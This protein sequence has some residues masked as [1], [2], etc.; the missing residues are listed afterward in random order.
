MTRP[1]HGLQGDSTDPEAALSSLQ[2]LVASAPGASADEWIPELANLAHGWS[3]SELRSAATS[4][5]WISRRLGH[6][7]PMLSGK[8]APAA[9]DGLIRLY[10]VGQRYRFDFNFHALATQLVPNVG[11]PYNDDALV[12]SFDAFARLGLR[13]DQAITRLEQVLAL[14]DADTRVR[15]VCLAGLWA[16][17][18]VPGQATLLLDLANAMIG[19]GEADGNVYFRR[20]AAYRLLGRP[21]EALDDIDYA[22]SLLPPGNNE[23]NQDYLRERQ[24]IGLIT[25][26][27]N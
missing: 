4:L 1:P 24:L 16:A 3:I 15:H 18:T 19:R 21:K 27:H 9:P 10:V 14:P 25:Q 7:I 26:F 17:Y 5:T 20:A 6:P 22:L 12:Q 11:P 8:P 23:I 2:D 13:E